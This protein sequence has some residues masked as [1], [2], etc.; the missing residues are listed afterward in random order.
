MRKTISVLATLGLLAVAVP[1]MALDLDLE[2]DARFGLGLNSCV[3]DGD[4][5]CDDIGPS[6]SILLAPGVRFMKYFGAY[7]DINI[8]WMSPDEK[9]TGADSIS[10]LQIMPV[11]R[12]IYTIGG[13]FPIEVFG[14]LG[15]GYSR[16]GVSRQSMGQNYS[17]TW[18]SF[19]N[20]KLNAGAIYRLNKNLGVG[21][22]IDFIFNNNGT[23]EHCEEANGN[24]ECHD[25]PDDGELSDVLQILIMGS[26]L[27]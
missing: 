4:D 27:F 8:G 22:N 21:L 25:V 11:F 10:T 19:L 24:E 3:S 23:G 1:A 9:K 5:K 20:A 6:V 7:L 18:S 17:G 26:Y 15:G 13:P 14:G 12:G 16:A 2:Y